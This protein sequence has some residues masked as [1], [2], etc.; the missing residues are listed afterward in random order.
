L[1]ERRC[2]AGHSLTLQILGSIED[3]KDR[4]VGTRR[5]WSAAPTALG[6]ILH[7]YPALPGW[8]DVWRAG[9]TGLD[10]LLG[11]QAQHEIWV[12]AGLLSAVPAGSSS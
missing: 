5:P 3:G 7:Q 4:D 11:H 10:D 9:P 2:N 8:A 6:I 1:G 12:R